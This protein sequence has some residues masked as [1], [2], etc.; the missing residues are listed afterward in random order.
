LSAAGLTTDQKGQISLEEISE[1]R[2]IIRNRTIVKE[3]KAFRPNSVSRP[4][5][6]HAVPQLAPQDALQMLETD[7]DDVFDTLPH[8]AEAL[9][10]LI[11]YDHSDQFASTQEQS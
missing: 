2:F 6:I 10:K 7:H 5:A 8:V 9:E 11:C 4:T 1:I 3:E